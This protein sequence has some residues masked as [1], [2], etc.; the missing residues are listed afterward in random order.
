MDES[1]DHPEGRDGAPFRYPVLHGGQPCWPDVASRRQ[2]D[3]RQH[4]GA[5]R[6]CNRTVRSRRTALDAPDGHQ[7]AVSRR[8]RLG[9][10]R[11]GSFVGRGHTAVH[12]AQDPA[13]SRRADDRHRHAHR[14][15]LSR[16][17]LESPSPA[18]DL[19]HLR[20]QGTS[21]REPSQS[22]LWVHTVPGDG[23]VR[24]QN[25]AELSR[26]WGGLRRPWRRGRQPPCSACGRCS[27]P[28]WW[29]EP[30]PRR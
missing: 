27:R 30:P 13:H 7:P 28:C 11:D 29:E 22:G 4:V 25:W 3:G 21:G 8:A 18:T 16:P 2:R 6:R 9:G 15:R 19:P 5:P 1:L 20:P 12:P 26:R 10:E 14:P 24:T 17:P 23:T